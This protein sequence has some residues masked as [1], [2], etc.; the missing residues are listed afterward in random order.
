MY[1]TLSLLTMGMYT[2]L[3]HH[4]AFLSARASYYLFGRDASAS[5][6]SVDSP[7]ADRLMA[8]ASWGLNTSI[9]SIANVGFYGASLAG[10]GSGSG[11]GTTSE[12]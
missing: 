10:W 4:L 5:A 12:L 2:Y 11:S 1:L 7:L 9:A 6:A 8:A 3:P